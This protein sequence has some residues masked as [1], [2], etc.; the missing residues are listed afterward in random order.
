MTTTRPAWAY[1]LPAAL[2]LMA[3][4]DIL[5]SLAMDIYLPVVPA[6]PGVLNTTPSIIQLTLSLYMVMLGV[7]QVIFGPLSDRVGRRP[8]LLVGA[9]A[10][11]AASLGAACSS[12][13]LA[14]V[15]FRLVQAVG[16]SAMLV[17]TFATVRDVYANR[18]EG[19]VIYGL[20]SSMLAFVPALGPIAGALIGEFWGWQAIF[21][22]LAAL[23]SLALLN[24][25][26]RWHETR[27]LD[28]ARTQRSVLPIFASPAFWVYTVGFSAGMGTFFVFFS[29]AP[30]VLIGQAGYSEIGFS[31]AFAT[32]ALVMVTTTRFAKSFVA[33]W[34]IAVPW[35]GSC[36][37]A[38]SAI[39]A[40]GIPCRSGEPIFHP[41]PPSWHQ[42]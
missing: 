5:A 1:T 31:L 16:A 15:A 32:V 28:Q 26:F 2:L 10:F 29:T 19:A 12:T 22:T 36:P 14:F 42:G 11:V 30:R 24:A 21:I 3:P 39:P 6:M 38:G 20:F 40:S 23:A 27:P 17:A 13:A 9:T 7:G 41:P 37:S 34:G 35:S 8:I 18:P 33:K 25:S 4:F